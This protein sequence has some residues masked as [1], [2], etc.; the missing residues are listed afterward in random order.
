MD[1]HKLLQNGQLEV[2]DTP[3][4]SAEVTTGS[5]NGIDIAQM[6]RSGSKHPLPC[7]GINYRANIAALASLG[8]TKVV[9]TAMV[10]SLRPSVPPSTLVLLDQFLDFTKHREWTYYDLEDF[11][12]V[13]FTEPYCPQLRQRLLSIAG[14]AGI[15]LNP[16]ACYV[17]VDGPR[18]ETRAEVQM[19][20]QLGGDVIGMTI[21]PECVIAREAGLCYSVIAGVVNPGAG[22]A[23]VPLD[24]ED[25]L[26]IRSKHMEDMQY[27]IQSLIETSSVHK[28]S[29]Q[30]CSCGHA[31]RTQRQGKRA[32]LRR[33]QA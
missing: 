28:D 22:L 19:Y 11:A 15:H 9:A 31:A 33:V 26:S 13:D 23:S 1:G 10:G 12:F 14:E 32:A 30:S 27:L 29:E 5:S 6:T 21:L 3:Y 7:H 18:F 25:F 17:C 20:S 24:A 16:S 4:G 8:V 2:I